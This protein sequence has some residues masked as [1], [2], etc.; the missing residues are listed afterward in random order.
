MRVG[1]LYSGN[2]EVS[3]IGATGGSGTHIFL[4]L[5]TLA[6]MGCDVTLFGNGDANTHSD[7]A[8]IKYTLVPLRDKRG[9]RG[10]L[11]A[12]AREKSR[13]DHLDLLII[14]GMV[15]I[16]V[17][18]MIC[19][20]K[21]PIV[22]V[23]FGPQIQYKDTIDRLL[24]RN[25]ATALTYCDTSAVYEYYRN[26]YPAHKD[27]FAWQYSPIEFYGS[28]FTYTDKYYTFSRILTLKLVHNASDLADRFNLDLDIYGCIRNPH[29]TK[30]ISK[31]KER[32]KGYYGVSTFYSQ[33]VL[34]GIH[35]QTSS[36]EGGTVTPVQ[37]LAHGIPI[38]MNIELHP[39][40]RLDVLGKVLAKGPGYEICRTGVSIDYQN[41]DNF[42]W[43][44]VEDYVKSL[45]QCR[46]D[47][48]E[49][50]K[51]FHMDNYIKRYLSD[52]SNKLKG[53]L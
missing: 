20:H 27:R 30:R 10:T 53:V 41:I 50:A 1:F 42:N 48:I 9:G 23:P 26:L 28:N 31:F 29:Y 47:I 25:P 6:E 52:V 7:L 2:D 13:L 37:A 11:K 12:F 8:S 17:I 5:K 36:F 4:L 16:D 46:E 34:P 43:R 19:E 39:L 33:K 24:K 51:Q 22:N 3:H 14:V 15:R 44:E 45:S 49:Y 32:Y 35:M 21:V 40:I 18:D 38:I